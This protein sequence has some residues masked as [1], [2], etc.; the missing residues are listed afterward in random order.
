MS[1]AAILAAA[2]LF[3]TVPLALLART[4]LGQAR[5]IEVLEQ[6]HTRTVQRL[7]TLEELVANYRPYT[8]A[9]RRSDRAIRRRIAEAEAE[10]Q[11]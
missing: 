8:S 1:P 11:H 9:A 4:L 3:L 5:R 10:E 6:E 7:E 2:V